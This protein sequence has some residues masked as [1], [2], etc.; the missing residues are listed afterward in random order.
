M[1]IKFHTNTK[2][3]ANLKFIYILIFRILKVDGMKT[4]FD[5]FQSL[6]SS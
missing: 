6:F 1:V 3:V 2:Q 5:H 4:A